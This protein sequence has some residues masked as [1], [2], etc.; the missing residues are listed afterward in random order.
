MQAHGHKAFTG[1]WPRVSRG[2]HWSTEN[3]C[4]SYLRTSLDRDL[5]DLCLPLILGTSV[6]N[7]HHLQCARG[8]RDIN[9]IKANQKL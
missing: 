9:K 8:D 6:I 5:L 3:V 2:G 7:R 1:D 4:S